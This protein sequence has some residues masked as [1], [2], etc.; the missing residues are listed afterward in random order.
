MLQYSEIPMMIYKDFYC[1]GTNLT[2]QR[3][4]VFSYQTTPNMPLALAV[5]ISCAIPLFYEPVLLDSA[6]NEMQVPVKSRNYQVYADGGILANYPINLFDT[7]ANG[8]NPLFCESIKHNY[9]TL[10]FKLDRR[11]QVDALSQTTDIQPYEINTLDDFMGATMNLMLEALNRKPNLENE[12]GRT[13]YIPYS[14][15]TTAA[16]K[17]MTLKQQRELYENGKAATELFLQ[18]HL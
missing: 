10:G 11:E 1:I 6:G 17:K 4:E 13:I 18:V 3:A 9:R 7:C 8:G 16:P 2:R 5:R 15:N 12:K 14:G